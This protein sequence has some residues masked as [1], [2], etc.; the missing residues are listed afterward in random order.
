MES[1]ETPELFVT[2]IYESKK[3]RALLTALL[4]AGALL[5]VIPLLPPVQNAIFSFVDARISRRGAGG[6]FSDRLSSLLSLPFAGFIVCVFFLCCAFSKRIAAFLEE[7]GNEKKII[8]AATGITV[9]LLVFIAVFS[10]RHGRQ[11]LDS[12]HSSEMILGKMLA[13]ENVLASRNWHYSTELRLIYQTIFTMPLFKLLGG[14]GNWALIRAINIFLNNAVLIA[15]Y[16]FMMKQ[17]GIQNKWTALGSLLLLLPVSKGYW[18]IVTFGGYYI[19]FI[20]QLFCCLGLFFRL[21][22]KSETTRNQSFTV[23]FFMFS[24]LTLALG[25]QGIRSLLSVYI[26]L[27]LTCLWP[28]VCGKKPEQKTPLFLGLYGFVIC[29]TGFAVNYLLHFRYSFHSFDNTNFENL[30]TAI[31]QKTGQCLAYFPKFFGYFEGERLLSARGLFGAA[32]L[33]ASALLFPALKFFGNA[34]QRNSLYGKDANAQFIFDFF[35]CAAAF[36]IFIFII[37]EGEVSSRYYIPFMVLYV[38]AVSIIFE[39][40]ENNYKPLKRIVIISSLVLFFSGQA[41]L[42]FQSLAGEDSNKQRNGYIQYLLDKRLDY[43]FATF[44]NASVTTELCDGAIEL[45]G[46]E[47]DGLH[48]G[49][50]EFRI[51]KWL[52]PEQFFNPS[53]HSGGSFLLLSRAEW[54]LARETGR[55]FTQKRPDY[56]DDNFIVIRYPSAEMIHREVLDD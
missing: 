41:F 28:W 53:Y 36:N 8:T 51:L 5:C 4:I 46:L 3:L 33:A 30:Q 34:K 55:P 44:W 13:E 21:A 45:A 23:D 38:P 10:Y 50:N 18:G 16:V 12:D 39:K 11:W 15:S 25:I 54:D 14:L 20:A 48:P 52:N 7:A 43:C 35:V 2:R 26:P 9:L 42:N 27:L 19:F 6:A 22:N 47:P 37:T 29:C 56:E 17:L 24:A 32:A 31:M 40:V 49:R 1:N